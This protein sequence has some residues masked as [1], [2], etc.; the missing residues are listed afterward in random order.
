[1]F[2]GMRAV[3]FQGTF[4]IDHFVAAIVLNAIYVLIGSLMLLWS[5]R[6]ARHTGALLQ[7]GE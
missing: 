1:V 5:F 3:L 2:E 4:R 6:H 7:L